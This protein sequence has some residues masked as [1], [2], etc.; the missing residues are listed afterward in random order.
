MGKIEGQAQGLCDLLVLGELLS[1]VRGEGV[2]AAFIRE[3]QAADLAP[4]FRGRLALGQSNQ[5][6][7]GFSF[8]EGDDGPPLALSQDRI[9]LPVP[10]AFSALYDGRP[11]LNALDI[12]QFS[13]AIILPEPFPALAEAAQVPV[14]VSAVVLVLEDVLIDP[15]MADADPLLA[16]QPARDLLGTPFLPEQLFDLEP[17]RLRD[18]VDRLPPPLHGLELSPERPVAS[19]RVVAGNLTAYGGLVDVDHLGDLHIGM[20]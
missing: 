15:F 5:R 11:I 9:D 8:G 3:Q 16:S 4:Y 6:E 13:P 1:V 14:Q 10:Q 19:I 12:G 18:A 20:T 7:A 2:D 17:Q